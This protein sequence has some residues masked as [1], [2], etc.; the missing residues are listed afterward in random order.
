MPT[1]FQK[2]KLGLK[3]KFPLEESQKKW[4]KMDCLFKKK[5]TT[6]EK[7]TKSI[8]IGL[9]LMFAH[10]ANLFLETWN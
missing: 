6:E 2:L 7:E 3:I 4:I 5:L 8:Q 10:Y 1:H 9:I